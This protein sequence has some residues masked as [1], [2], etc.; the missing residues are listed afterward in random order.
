MIR[1]R[2]DVWMKGAVTVVLGLVLPPAEAAAQSPVP[3]QIRLVVPFP[4][5][6]PTD[7]VARP[8]AQMLGGTAQ[9]GGR[10]RQSRRG[11]RIA[12]GGRRRQVCAGRAHAADGDDGDPC[13]QSGALPQA[14]PRHGTNR[15]RD[16]AGGAGRVFGAL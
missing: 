13:H 3:A 5:G 15:A 8:F 12:G 2:I 11:G 14:S 10:H 16:S 9:G 1:A 7:I 4:A 6:G